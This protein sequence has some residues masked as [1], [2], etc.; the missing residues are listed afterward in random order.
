MSKKKSTK[1]SA[2]AASSKA[3]RTVKA[4]R[5]PSA[6]KPN[7]RSLTG[8]KTSTGAKLPPG[9]AA[10]VDA[11]I[12]DAAPFA[13][14]IMEKIRAIFHKASPNITETMKWNVPHFEYRGLLGG[15]AA[16]KNHVSLGFWKSKFMDDPA[17]LF[18]ND[19]KASMCTLKLAAVADIPSE[20]VLLAYIRQAMALN[21][22]DAVAQQRAQCAALPKSPPRPVVVPP[23]L[24]AALKQPANAAA[25]ETFDNFPPSHKREYVEWITE[26]KRDET[27]QSR[28]ETTL[29]WLNEGKSK[30]WKYMKR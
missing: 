14:P 6:K 1:R 3:A 26:A 8:G 18:N 30:N 28:L 9:M 20:K 15:M 23:D 11:Y 22:P 12:H 5:S 21:E 25:R 24:A 13:R 17:N 4:A 27:R 2:V 7:G 10:V 29:E 16:F 19:P